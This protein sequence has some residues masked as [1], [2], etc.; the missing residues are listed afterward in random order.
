VGSILAY[1]MDRW[2]FIPALTYDLR[3]Y[4]YGTSAVVARGLIGARRCGDFRL[5]SH[6]FFLNSQRTAGRVIQRKE[7]VYRYITD[8]IFLSFSFVSC[9]MLSA[10]VSSNALPEYWRSSWR[11]VNV[12]NQSI[13]QLGVY[14]IVGM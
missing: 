11:N 3:E 1:K 7:R 4:A 12:S 14:L 6:S 9:S 13:N 10:W 8:V 5:I 2:C